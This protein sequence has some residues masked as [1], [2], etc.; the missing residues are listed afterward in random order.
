MDYLYGLPLIAVLVLAWIAARQVANRARRQRELLRR[1]K[2]RS[3]RSLA[4]SPETVTSRSDMR[5]T[6][7]PVTVIE[8]IRQRPRAPDDGVA[9]RPTQREK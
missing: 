6:D 2:R 8:K 3:Q 7:S 1:Q 5:S 4:D 9:A